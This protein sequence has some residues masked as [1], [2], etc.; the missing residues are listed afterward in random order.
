MAHQIVQRVA[1]IQLKSA[2]YLQFTIRTAA[3]KSVIFIYSF[4]AVKIFLE[5][6]YTQRIA[7]ISIPDIM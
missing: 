4:F 7:H 2:P 5:K 1:G 3:S 6:R